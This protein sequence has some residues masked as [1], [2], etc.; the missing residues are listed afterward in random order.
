MHHVCRSDYVPFMRMSAK[1]PPRSV[2]WLNV[3]WYFHSQQGCVWAQNSEVWRHTQQMK[4]TYIHANVKWFEWVCR[5]IRLDFDRALYDNMSDFVRGIAN[6]S[7][8]DCTLVVTRVRHPDM[9]LRLPWKT[10]RAS[11]MFTAG[12]VITTRSHS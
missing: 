4:R 10:R 6:V 5:R 12:L 3:R 7:D 1:R 8:A 11:P 9:T 2:R